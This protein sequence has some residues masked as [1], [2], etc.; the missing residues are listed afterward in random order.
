MYCQRQHPSI[1][2]NK[3]ICI[4]KSHFSFTYVE[5]EE[6]LNELNDLNI[7]KATQNSDILTKIIK[8]NSDIFGEFIFQNL[9]GCLNTSLYPSVLKIEDIQP[10]HKKDS[11]SAKKITDQLVL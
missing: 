1:D 6:I 4:S 2:G 3:K 7:N 10:V 5:N 11:K 8:E 9:N